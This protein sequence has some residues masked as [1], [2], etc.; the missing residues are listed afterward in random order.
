MAEVE[1][2]CSE[3]PDAAG[4][5]SEAVQIAPQALN[6][7]SLLAQALTQE[8][9]IKEADEAMRLEASIRQRFVQGQRDSRD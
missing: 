5:L 3:F 1:L 8:G 2:R 9:R 6:Y 7:H 4:H